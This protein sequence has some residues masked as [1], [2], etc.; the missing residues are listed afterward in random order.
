MEAHKRGD[1]DKSISFDTNMSPA[2]RYLLGEE[3]DDEFVYEL[4]YK[5]KSIVFDMFSEIISKL[6]G[7]GIEFS[8]D[9]NDPS[10]IYLKKI[11]PDKNL[12]EKK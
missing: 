3:L 4:S 9:E 6:A 10:V 5:Y 2:F 1:I 11:N 7:E 8:V 12:V